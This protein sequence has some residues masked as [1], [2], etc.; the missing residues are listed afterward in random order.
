MGYIVR[1]SRDRDMDYTYAYGQ[2]DEKY[3]ILNKHE[4]TLKEGSDRFTS[5]IEFEKP[6]ELE[7]NEK[8]EVTVFWRWEEVDDTLDTLIGNHAAEKLVNATIND[9][10]RLS[11]GFNFE[12][13]VTS[14]PE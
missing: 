2:K 7:P 4:N 13:K 10:Y 12:T 9:M 3:W 11:I 1:Y 8:V 5:T 14:C 6:I